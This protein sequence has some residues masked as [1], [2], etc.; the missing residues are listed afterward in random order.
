[1]VFGHTYVERIIYASGDEVRTV[2]VG[3]NKPWIYRGTK[4]GVRVRGEAISEW[5]PHT[6]EASFGQIHIEM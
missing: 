6:G 2:S 5:A 3:S 4:E 1:M